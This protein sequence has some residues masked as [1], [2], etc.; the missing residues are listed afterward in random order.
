M[1]PPVFWVLKGDRN[2]S[3]EQVLLYPIADQLYPLADL[4]Y[5]LTDLLYLNIGNVVRLGWLIAWELAQMFF[6]L[7]LC[8]DR[9]HARGKF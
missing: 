8:L 9:L 3:F 4:L 6:L 5:P 7:V 2:M 1:E